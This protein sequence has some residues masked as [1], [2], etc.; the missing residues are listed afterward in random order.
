[1]WLIH[2][3]RSLELWLVLAGSVNCPSMTRC[4]LLGVSMLIGLLASLLPALVYGRVTALQLL[5]FQCLACCVTDLA[6]R[7]P[8][9]PGLCLYECLV[10]CWQDSVQPETETAV[11]LSLTNQTL[12]M[13][14]KHTHSSTHY[15]QKWIWT[16]TVMHFT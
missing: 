14:C 4:W 2:I 15:C 8:S 11:D 9:V 5:A 3:K 12:V 6:C 7:K 10:S 1:M 16:F 13:D